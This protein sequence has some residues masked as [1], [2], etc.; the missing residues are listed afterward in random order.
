MSPIQMLYLEHSFTRYLDW[1][2]DKIT[3]KFAFQAM[4]LEKSFIPRSIWMAGDN[5]SNIIEVSHSDVNREG[6]QCSLVGGIE[7]GR[8][9]DEMKLRTLEV[10]L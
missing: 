6:T 1:V 7:K 10:R 3:S 9:Y 5:T 2:E 8:H 4:C